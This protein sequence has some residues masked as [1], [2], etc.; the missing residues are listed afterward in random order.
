M[1]ISIYIYMHPAWLNIVPAEYPRRNRQRF[2]TDRHVRVISARA[3]ARAMQRA[4]CN[5]AC[6]DA[7]H[8]AR[9]MNPR[10]VRYAM[11]RAACKPAPMQR[12]L[13]QH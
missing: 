1:H 8:A 6:N 13:M 10:N 4:T 11:Q 2:P 12:A 5:A 3:S 9:S 7:Q